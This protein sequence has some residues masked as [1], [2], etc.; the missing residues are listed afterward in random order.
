MIVCCVYSFPSGNLNQFT[1]LLEG[2]L[3]HL[4]QPSVTFLICGDLNVN[5]LLESLAKQTLETLMK[6]FNLT[7]VVNFSTRIYNNKGTSIDS[8]FWII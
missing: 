5:F 7:Q 3:K 4:Y 8:I 6:T 1:K 2:I